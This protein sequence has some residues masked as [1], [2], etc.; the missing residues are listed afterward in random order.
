MRC[1]VAIAV[2]VVT[3][4]GKASKPKSASIVATLETVAH[5]IAAP[6]T[7]LPSA[8][9]AAPIIPTTVTAV[10]VVKYGATEVIIVAIGIASVYAE[11]PVTRVVVKRTVEV[12]GLAVCPVL[13]I[14]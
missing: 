4:I 8:V 9:P 14:V 3:V 13:P 7:E 5:A 10:S 12:I 1:V 6:S 2:I 11:P